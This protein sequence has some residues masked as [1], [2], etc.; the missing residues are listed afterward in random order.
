M[1]LGP[2]T[3]APARRSVFC[4]VL[5]QKLENEEEIHTLPEEEKN[6]LSIRRE[7]IKTHHSLETLC[8]LAYW[9]AT[10]KLCLRLIFFLRKIKTLVIRI[11]FN[12]E[13]N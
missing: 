1:H 4:F 9:E 8:R 2:A 6:A 11:F 7:R 13:E 5:W 3:Q 10:S 12:V